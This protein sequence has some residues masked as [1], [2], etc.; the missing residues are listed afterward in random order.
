MW[1]LLSQTARRIPLPSQSQP[2]INAGKTN[3]PVHFAYVVASLP[4]G[5][6]NPAPIA[7]TTANACATGSCGFVN[8]DDIAL[9]WL[10]DQSMDQQVRDYLN[11]NAVPLFID[12]V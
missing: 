6:T 10:A 4:D 11:A 9:I 12:E 7:I 1:L 3:K 8:D 5:K 2:P